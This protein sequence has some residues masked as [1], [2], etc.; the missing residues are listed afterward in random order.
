MRRIEQVWNAVLI[1]IC[2]R[3][4]VKVSRR[5]VD[6]VFGEG[7]RAISEKNVYFLVIRDGEVQE[8]IAIEID[9]HDVRDVSHTSGQWFRCLERAI[10]IA[11]GN[12]KRTYEIEFVIVVDI[13][14]KCEAANI[15][16]IE[17][18]VVIGIL[19]GAVSL[20]RRTV[21]S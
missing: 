3:Q 13:N 19:E 5:I 18:E 15:S 1:Y 8:T 20:P 9:P 14:Q 12:T 17:I 16:S 4:A 7:T 11:E 6:Q 2:Y 10:A 21:T